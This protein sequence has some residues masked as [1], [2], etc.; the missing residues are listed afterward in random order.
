MSEK[1]EIVHWGQ[2]A[3]EQESL[4]LAQA[5]TKLSENFSDAVLRIVANK[6]KV[7][8]TGLGKSGHIARKIAATFA[9]T[10][11]PSFFMHPSEALHGDSGMVDKNDILLAIGFNGETREVVEVA[12]FAR[13]IG[14]CVISITGNL[15]SSLA[16]LSDI[17]LDGSVTAE[18]CPLN[19]APTSST[20]VALA[21]GDAL[22]VALMRKRGFQ[23]VDFARY[24]PEGALGRKLSL[25]KQH[26]IDIE[27][28]S[29]LKAHS[30]FKD[31]LHKVTQNNLG[32]S[33][34]VSDSKVVEGVVTDGDLRRAILEHQA[35]I[36]E[37]CAKDFM[38]K[39]PKLIGP[40]AL[41]VDALQVM[42]AKKITALL[43]VDDLKR[44]TLLGLVRMHD[45]LAAKII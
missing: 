41:A 5:A 11:T 34:V 38:T 2:R 23:E 17:V 10:G 13:R 30:S 35:A 45:L 9:S 18:A 6:G 7:V 31:T 40:N 22:A 39:E 29:L 24:H 15:N 16:S 1:N 37:L 36:F 43:V 33:A 12:K 3:L 32:I 26:M 19:L 20:T 4:A 27:R 28:I 25:V 44:K 42:E 14:V 8:L 21:L